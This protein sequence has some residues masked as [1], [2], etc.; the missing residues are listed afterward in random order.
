MCG[1]CDS[2]GMGVLDTDGDPTGRRDTT[3]DCSLCWW[4]LLLVR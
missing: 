2:G 4:W 3:A 1:L